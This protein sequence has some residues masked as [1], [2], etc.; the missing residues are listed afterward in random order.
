MQAASSARGPDLPETRWARS[1]EL[2]IAYQA[3]GGG[4]IDLLVAPGFVSHCEL[5]WQS[6]DLTRVFERLAEVARVIIFDKRD[7]GLSDRLGRPP[8]VEEMVD[9]A[10][11]VLDAAGS[12]RAAVFGISEGGALAQ[13]LAASHPDR[14]SHLL[15]WS[16][17]ARLCRAPDYPQGIDPRELDRWREI[18]RDEWGGPVS[19]GVFAPSRKGDPETERWWAQMLRSGTS[20]RGVVELMGLYKE[21]DVRPALESITAPTLVMHRRDDRGV[22]AELGRYI[23]EGIRGARY[24]EFPGRDHIFWTEGADEITD[25]IEEFLTGARRAR[26]A[27]R[28]LATVLFTDI[29]DSTAQAAR[30]GDR[31]WRELL[32]R[33]DARVAA[34]VERGRGRVVKSTGDGVLATFDGPA[35]AIETAS[36]L[37]AELPDLGVRIRA[38]LHTGECERRGEDVGGMAVHIGAR[39]ATRAEPGEVLVSSTVKDLVVGSGIEFSERGGAELKGVPGEWRLFAVAGPPV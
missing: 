28:V 7:Q 30:L 35:R 8:S 19:L 15:L 27:D 11:A 14:C 3:F 4:P 31:R 24:V 5:F 9:D 36:R 12:E 10:L 23:A 21:L 39:I 37:A 25:E 22:P 18:L 26:P 20:P 16:S 1:G 34:E 2:S 29:V 13:L 33:H 17:F 32:D 6:S 38:G